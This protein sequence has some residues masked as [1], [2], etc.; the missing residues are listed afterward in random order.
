MITLNRDRISYINSFKERK[1]RIMCTVISR[2]G[3]PMYFGRN[4]DIECSFREAVVITPRG[5]NPS[6]GRKMPF[7]RYS[8]IGMAA[9]SEDYPL[10][11]DAA[12]EKGGLFVSTP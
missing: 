5:Y 10:Y 12:N 1:K 9:V 6:S 3:S 7:M 4:M 2:E 8:V 11:A